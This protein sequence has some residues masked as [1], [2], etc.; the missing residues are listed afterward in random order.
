MNRNF[1]RVNEDPTYDDD[2]VIA[3][4]YIDD[5]DWEYAFG[6]DQ[7]WTEKAIAEYESKQRSA[8]L[9]NFDPYGAVKVK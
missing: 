9:E 7:G 3:D 8:A 5:S 1:W 4:E 6:S 2:G